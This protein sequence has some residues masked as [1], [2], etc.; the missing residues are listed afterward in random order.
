MI[1]IEN[2]FGTPKRN[3]NGLQYEKGNSNETK[4]A[5]NNQV[6]MEMMNVIKFD[7]PSHFL[8]PNN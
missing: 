4:N 6:E 8:L 2:N 1:Y 7:G 5:E 3:K